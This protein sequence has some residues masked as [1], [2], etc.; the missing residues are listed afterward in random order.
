MRAA[1]EALER[2]T[3]TT[4]D[5]L[6]DPAWSELRPYTEFRE[7]IRDHAAASK[8]CLTPRGEAGERLS[9]IGRVLDEKDAPRDKVLVYAYQ[10]SAKGWYSDKAPHVSG[11]SGDFKHARLFGYCRTD[12]EGRFELESVRPGGYPRSTLPQH[13]HFE[14]KGDDRATSVGEIW[15]DDDPRL[16][17]EE[18]AKSVQELCTIVTP[19]RGEDGAWRCEAALR[20][21]REK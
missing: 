5:L 19:R 15:F 7:L 1:K 8:A 6:G 16:T 14:L 20:L 2:K 12:A 11:N 17:P 3:S 9:M 21:R 13:I 4:N 18:R 10:T